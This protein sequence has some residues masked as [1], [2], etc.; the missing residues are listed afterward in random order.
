[1]Y[2]CWCEVNAHRSEVITCKAHYF[3]TKY[4]RLLLILSDP[5]YHINCD[6]TKATTTIMAIYDN[7]RTA[8]D[9]P[10]VVTTQ[11]ELTTTISVFLASAELAAQPGTPPTYKPTFLAIID[12]YLTS[13]N[14]TTREGINTY[15]TMVNLDHAWTRKALSFETATCMLDIFKDKE[16][17]YGLDDIL[18]S[19]SMVLA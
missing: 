2:T 11:E 3:N 10:P 19:P 1:M 6:T 9:A 7:I 16:I 18:E 12:P 13:I 4:T 17:Q 14:I 5:I 15:K 8:S